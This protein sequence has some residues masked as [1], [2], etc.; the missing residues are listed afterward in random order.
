[1]PKQ[2]DPGASPALEYSFQDYR[3]AFL[4]ALQGLIQHN[5]LNMASEGH[6]TAT[7]SNVDGLAVAAAKALT[8]RRKQFSAQSELLQS[9]VGGVS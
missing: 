9:K 4:A 8:V 3:D 7:V 5:G 1:M 6:F 2:S